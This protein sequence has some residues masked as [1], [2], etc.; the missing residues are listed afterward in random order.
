MLKASCADKWPCKQIN[1]I[2]GVESVLKGAGCPSTACLSLYFHHV[3]QE[4]HAAL[5]S[6]APGAELQKRL[7]VGWSLSQV[8]PTTESQYSVLLRWS[9]TTDIEDNEVEAVS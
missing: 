9:E 5:Q 4:L 8:L 6:G 7:N 3:A 2:C 1:C